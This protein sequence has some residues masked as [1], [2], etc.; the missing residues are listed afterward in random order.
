MNAVYRRTMEDAHVVENPFHG[1][2]SQ[3]FIAVF[4]GHGGV[5][6]ADAA[7]QKM[8]EIVADKLDSGIEPLECIRRAHLEMDE[9]LRSE[10][11]ERMIGST[12][13]V[14]YIH[15]SKLYVGNV[16]DS[17]VVICRKATRQA[18]RLTEDH[19]GKVLVEA[20]RVRALGG[21]VAC[22]YV[23]KKL[24]TG[25]FADLAVTR[26]LGDFLFK[27]WVSADPAL[28]ETDAAPGDVLVI[29][30][31]GLWDVLTDQ[32]ACELALTGADNG[33]TCLRTAVDLVNE[34]LRR[35]TTDNVSVIVAA[36]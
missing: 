11:A 3:A 32:Q 2:P 26:A 10:W 27:P 31:D 18:E 34:A 13:A 23:T 15:G 36:L 35:G 5:E 33:L 24:G 21:A 7:S 20:E 28:K 19:T 17:R 29:A 30:C 14:V 9:M 6:V 1:D 25:S 12:S 8:P 22:G 4:D 16:G